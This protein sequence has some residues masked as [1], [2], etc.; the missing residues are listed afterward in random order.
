MVLVGWPSVWAAWQ[1]VWDYRPSAPTN[2]VLLISCRWWFYFL[3]CDWWWVC[4]YAT[5][6]SLLFKTACESFT[7]ITDLN[8]RFQI[9][10]NFCHWWSKSI[11]VS[12]QGLLHCCLEMSWILLARSVMQTHQRFIRRCKGKESSYTWTWV[13]A[14]SVL[15][16]LQFPAATLFICASF[17]HVLLVHVPSL[18]QILGG[19]IGPVHPSVSGCLIYDCDIDVCRKIVLWQSSFLHASW[20]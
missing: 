20:S 11:W 6:S 17:P 2:L 16:S 19:K 13:D 5:T 10:F 12:V 9:H 4:Y 1:C 7:C 18:Y 3:L 8:T 15:A 14:V